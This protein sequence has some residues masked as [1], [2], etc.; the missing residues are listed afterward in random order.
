MGGG[1]ESEW[2]KELYKAYEEEYDEDDEDYD[3]NE[4]NSQEDDY[5]LV[6]K[7]IIL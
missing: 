3:P 1:A 5:C 6:M 7:K 4:D 2:I